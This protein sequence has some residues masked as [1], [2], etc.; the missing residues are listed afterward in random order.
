MYYFYQN[1][2][3][4]IQA[5]VTE[6]SNK[7]ASLQGR[8]KKIVTSFLDYY[9]MDEQNELRGMEKQEKPIESF[10]SQH[11]ERL[12]YIFSGSE[13]EVLV[14]LLGKEWASKFKKVWDRSTEYIYDT[15]YE[16]RSFRSKSNEMLYLPTGLQ[17]LHAL[18]QMV[19]E[20]FTYEMYFSGSN[21]TYHTYHT[22]NTIIPYLLALEIDEDNR[23]IINRIK[24]MVYAENNTGIL[25]RGIIKGLLMSNNQE[26][27]KWVG[28]LLLA[29]GRQ[30]GLRQSIVESMDEGSR[31]GFLYLLNIILENNLIRFSSIVRA[32]DVWTGLGIGA[33]KSKMIKKCLEAVCRCLKETD[34]IDACLESSDSQLIYI[35]LWSIAFDDIGSTEQR[36][37]RLLQAE[38]KYK[39]L[40]GLYFLSQTQFPT[41]QHQIA[42]PF[43]HD[44]D[45]E[46]KS[47]VMKN[48]FSDVYRI[49]VLAQDEKVHFTTIYQEGKDLE[50]LFVKLKETLDSLPKKE[51]KFHESVFPWCQTTI[52]WNDILAKMLIVM[53]YIPSDK[54]IDMLLDYKDKMGV[55]TR[56]QFVE[57]FLQK[58]ATSK[59]KEALLAFMGDRGTYVRDI[60]VKQV[61]K[62]TLSEEDYKR[63]EDLLRYKAGDLRKNVLT[64]LLKQSPE[65]L[66]GSIRRLI[67]NKN[68]S[69]QLAA[70]DII[71]KV[72]KDKKFVS[73][74]EECKD[75]V[76]SLSET[77]EAASI[78]VEN[79]REEKASGFSLENGLG[80]Y[81]PATSI[82][83]SAFTNSKD[84]TSKD[85][86]SSPIQEIKRVVMYFNDLVDQHKTYEYEV[87]NFNGQR[88]KVVLG[89]LYDI[90][91]LHYRNGD[92]VETLDD[93]PLAE[94]WRQAA[95]DQQLTTRRLLEVLFYYE[96]NQQDY[97][98]KKEWF[99]SLLEKL[100]PIQH[101]EFVEM[102]TKLPYG[103]H[104]HTIFTALLNESPSEEVFTVCKDMLAFIY[105]ETP[106]ERFA[107]VYEKKEGSFY[108][109]YES[110][111]V[112]AREIAFWYKHLPKYTFQEYFN[113]GYCFYQAS[114]YKSHVCL[115]L[116]DFET[117]YK[118]GIVDENELFRELCGRPLS[119]KNLQ[120]LTNTDHYYHK[121]VSIC[122]KLQEVGKKVVD[123]VVSMELKRGELTT[124]VS[125]LA[126]SIH[127][128]IGT[129]FFVDI[130]VGM[131][132]DTFVRGYNFVNEDSTKKQIFSHLLKQC[133]PSSGEDEETLRGLLQGKK[134][135]DRQLI[136]AVMYSP[137]WLPIVEKYLQWPG[138]TSAGWYFHGHINEMFS[139]E[140]ETM[141]ARYTPIPP[142]DLKQGTFDI[143][144]FKEAYASLGEK[145]FAV[146][147]AS[148][149]YIAGGGLHKRSQ[150][151]TDAT[152][153]KLDEN[154]VEMRITEK[155]NKDYILSYGLLPF[156]KNKEEVL[157]RYVFLQNFLKQSKQFGA[158]RRASEASAVSISLENL[159][160]NAGFTDKNRL[161]WNMETEKV[162]SLR[163][164]LEP[165]V[166]QDI[167]V[168]LHINELGKG[169]LIVTKEGKSLKTIPSRLK[170]HEYIKEI[171]A[172][173]KSLQEQ[174][175]R[176]RSMLEKAMEG[177]ESFTSTEMENLAKHP[178]LFP[179]MKNLL[180]M[181][182]GRIG[183]Y[184]NNCLVGM[185]EQ[186]TKLSAEDRCVLAHPVY[187]Y[188]SGEWSSF[189]KDLFS[190]GIVQP[191]KQVFRELYKPNKDEMEARTVSHRYDGYQIQPKKT[192][193][194]LRERG[195]TVSFEE[196]LQKVFYKENI[197]AQLF[198]MA[199]W[200]TPADVEAPTLQEIRFTHRKTGEAVSFLEVP[201]VLFSE[202]MRDVDL[203]V[204]VAHVG[205]V[206]PEASLST[207]EMRTAIIGETLRLLQLSN[208][209]LKGSHAYIKGSLGEYTVHLGSGG[210]HKLGTGAMMII[211]VHN[212]HRGRIFLPFVDED[213]K[214]VEITTKIVTLAEDQKIKDPTILEQI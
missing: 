138:L 124:E 169:K 58:P 59:Q 166:V 56:E 21:D 107:E 203:V 63:I 119:P 117:A 185:D 174:Y 176:A 46:V 104:V 157:H 112:E 204:S 49:Y 64:I 152:L 70:I 196:G 153:G 74:V 113:I 151:F 41:F 38:E 116:Q 108:I 183:Y 9:K 50:E 11:S 158:Q 1:H 3:E 5:Y 6:V 162:T 134:I 52:S 155:R 103:K 130:I 154:D 168:H 200:F 83:V 111:L 160:R 208:V 81:D 76:T 2:N 201:K 73:I 207:I 194:L 43:L 140:K 145:R 209:E 34:Y 129:T 33:E 17:K 181:N 142:E 65:R 24:D 29:A 213:P 133:Y 40:V 87:E 39:R 137:Q 72:E 79:I 186:V 100:F 106:K 82:R 77:T 96:F 122:E 47:W 212:Q 149:K 178:V 115:K 180:F 20:G 141:I 206:D 171:K 118:C 93:Y 126:A 214:T 10:W 182:G 173:S 8:N 22:S 67:N 164:F 114:E 78:L 28:E 62:L 66:L 60:A 45:Y 91:S 159:A 132:R 26:A 150:L 156:G 202:V 7:A 95:K 190:K 90:C 192:V 61:K 144:W 4:D 123:R 102:I 19:G 15:G 35:G 128:C 146:V 101:K 127:K 54:K 18:F 88:E 191:F 68:E 136:D 92:H 139:P 184:R 198:A 199:D 25:T 69:K 170:N 31:E 84:F 121:S 131:G 189:Q 12:E 13:F 205:G 135:A 188:E 175:T 167:E 187:L 110:V 99:P 75:L 210:V 105:H 193:A 125:H 57:V 195:W 147:Y 94:T 179:L 98:S 55:D 177:Q 51:L 172:V 16:R 143:D 161:I 148:A 120:L 86:L 80:L 48:L 165:A 197:I 14:T 211:P 53:S 97:I 71:S 27:H 37:K 23:E 30:E 42:A 44:P 163:R 109:G 32:L 89:G 36:L 85:I